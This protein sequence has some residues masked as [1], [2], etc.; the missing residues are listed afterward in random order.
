[1]DVGV[2]SLVGVQPAGWGAT[3]EGGQQSPILQELAVNIIDRELCNSQQI[4][5]GVISDFMYC[6]GR[7]EGGFDSCQGDSGGPMICVEDGEPVLT[8]VVSWGFGCARPNF[9]GVYAHVSKLSDWIHETTMGTKA[10]TSGDTADREIQTQVAQALLPT[11]L[12]CKNPLTVRSGEKYEV[13]KI[14]G[15]QTARER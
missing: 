10:P 4:Y 14:V 5:R 2:L 7:L 6:G 3:S 15:G 1:M 9:P 12:V 8:G 13:N 11:N